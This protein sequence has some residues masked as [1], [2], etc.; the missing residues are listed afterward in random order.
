MAAKL[1]GSEAS[2][3]TKKPL[4]FDNQLVKQKPFNRLCLYL[5]SLFLQNK[6]LV[7]V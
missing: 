5:T 4:V 7:K 6:L 2:E 1:S 3:L